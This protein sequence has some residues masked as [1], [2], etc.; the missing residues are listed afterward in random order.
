MP[1]TI[2]SIQKQIAALEKRAEAI[3]KAELADAAGKVKALMT[4]YGLTADDLGLPARA[5]KRAAG[6]KG[7]SARKSSAPKNPGAPKYQDPKTGKTWTGNG[8]A[9]GWIAGAK[10]REPFLI[11]PVNAAAPSASSAPSAATTPAPAKLAARRAKAVAAAA[12]VK[13][14]SA[15]RASAKK[16]A[17]DGGTAATPAATP[18][19]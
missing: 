8:K 5:G 13:R 19:A 3:R 9:P 14:A 18:S 16:A 12:P 1:T 6:P 2:A 7:K 15:K 10:N 17:A 4:R 11:N